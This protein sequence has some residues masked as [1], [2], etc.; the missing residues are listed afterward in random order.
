MTLWNDYY[1]Y[2]SSPAILLRITSKE[3]SR[4]CEMA[5]SRVIFSF[6]ETEQ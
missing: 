6:K 3:K 4:L 5:L 2:K 1:T